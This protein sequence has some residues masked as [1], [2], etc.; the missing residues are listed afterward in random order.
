MARELAG[1][2][3]L[4]G[5]NGETAVFR[6]GT[7]ERDLPAEVRKQI[8]NPSA[9]NGDAEPAA[10]QRASEGD[11][12]PKGGVGSTR[13]AWAAYADSHDVEFND[14]ATRD[15]IIA[16]CEAASVPTE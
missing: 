4:P 10:A 5:E 6:A 7:A 1:T 9:W 15:E 14:D 13:D 2:V 3:Y 8:T 11:V 12:P 16:A